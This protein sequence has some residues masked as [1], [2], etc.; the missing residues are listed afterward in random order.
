VA[1][2]REEGAM[3]ISIANAAFMAAEREDASRGMDNVV[4]VRLFP[5]MEIFR[6][7]RASDRTAWYAA[8]WWFGKSVHDALLQY[9]H[10]NAVS[11]THGARTCF[12]VP[13]EWSSMDVLLRAR[14]TQPLSAWSGTPR[15]VRTKEQRLPTEPLV[16]PDGSVLL[17]GSGHPMGGRY[18]PRWEPDRAMTQL[19]IP[20]LRSRQRKDA[21]V[22]WQD[23]LAVSPPLFLAGG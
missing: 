2:A 7:G 15:S 10:A 22:R 17:P 21:G 19:Y 11:L 4:H 16:R 9:C 23:V 6:F 12:A 1:D 5:A 14:V 18:G 13:P 3:P 20:G 8:S